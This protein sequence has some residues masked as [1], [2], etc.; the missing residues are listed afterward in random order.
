M[1]LGFGGSSMP[2]DAGPIGHSNK[3]CPTRKRKA[4]SDS[5]KSSAAPSV[6]PAAKSEEAEM[7]NLLDQAS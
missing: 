4:D 1:G 5:A 2:F 6:P 3:L 7:G